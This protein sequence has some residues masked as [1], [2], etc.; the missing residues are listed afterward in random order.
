[1]MIKAVLFD[2][3]GTLLDIDLESF[4]GRYF[5]SLRDVAQEIAGTQ[6][7]DRVMDAIDSAVRAMSEP[8]PGRTNL[9]VFSA[10]FERISGVVLEDVWPSYER[11]YADVFPTLGDGASPAEGA[12]QAIETAL[13][14]GLRVAIATNPI[15][16]RVAVEHRLAWAGLGDLDLPVVTSYEQMVATKP[17]P[18]YYMQV[19]R[20]LSVEPSDCL[21]V[22]D[23]RYLDLP[24]ADVGM[25]TFYVG[26]H[27]DAVADYR[28]NLDDL[29]EL[30]PRLTATDGA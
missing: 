15:F 29:S 11:F 18:A 23:D 9:A 6:G 27:G 2:L 3:D 24:A 22:G 4:L 7:A 16:P 25:R 28:G 21:M 17:H 30:L 20:L 12:R 8:H 19:A 5:T 26:R 10:E 14:L 1:M 13:A